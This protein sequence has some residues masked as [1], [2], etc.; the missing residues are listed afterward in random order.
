M[1]APAALGNQIA[2]MALPLIA[3]LVMIRIMMQ[4]GVVRRDQQQRLEAFVN[5]RP[6][7]ATK[8]GLAAR[9][10]DDSK[11]LREAAAVNIHVQ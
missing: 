11:S 3:V 7:P 8:K 6:Q 1:V 10:P 2:L 4:F 5:N 9:V